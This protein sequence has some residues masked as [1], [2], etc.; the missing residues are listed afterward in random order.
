MVRWPEDIL[1]VSTLLKKIIYL[2]EREYIVR[3]VLQAIICFAAVAGLAAEI[4]S[5]STSLQHS[6][7]CTES[8]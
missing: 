8:H 6:F 2:Q 5:L 3:L 7:N 1:Q 4:H